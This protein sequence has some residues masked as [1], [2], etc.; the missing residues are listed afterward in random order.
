MN[1]SLSAIGRAGLLLTALW[2]WAVPA[3]AQQESRKTGDTVLTAGVVLLDPGIALGKPVL[4]FP[5]SYQPGSEVLPTRFL[6]PTP[7]YP[8]FFL[9]PPA[10]PRADLLS[11]YLL[12]LR[13]SQEMSTFYTIL[14]AMELGAVAYV[15]YRHVKKFGF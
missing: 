8:P 11:P 3:P 9:G 15:A 1:I 6:S 12:G 14:G 2:C 5:P 13:R 4:L 10:E 7:V